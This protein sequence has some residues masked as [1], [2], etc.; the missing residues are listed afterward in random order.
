[1]IFFQMSVDK[2]HSRH[3]LRDFQLVDDIFET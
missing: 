1:M 3:I 2:R